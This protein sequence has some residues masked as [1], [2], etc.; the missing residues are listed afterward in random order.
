MCSDLEEEHE[1]NG[2]QATPNPDRFPRSHRLFE[3]HRMAGKVAL[4]MDLAVLRTIPPASPAMALKK[5]RIEQG[6]IH[7]SQRPGDRQPPVLILHQKIEI[8][9]ET[10]RISNRRLCAAC[11]VPEQKNAA[12]LSAIVPD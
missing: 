5:Q 11:P 4:E 3:I 12:K 1:Q 8:G 7:G 9:I 6:T 2:D 10:V